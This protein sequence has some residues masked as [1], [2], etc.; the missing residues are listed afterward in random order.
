M[1]NV[2]SIRKIENCGGLTLKNGKP[3]VYR[4]GWQVA[5]H[6]VECNTPEETMKA[7][8]SFGG[9]CGIWREDKDSKP[10]Y[11]VD[12]SFRVDTKRQALEIGRNHNQISVLRWKG[13]KLV[14]C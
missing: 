3:I 6:G 8:K 5:T 11:Y 7:I 10:V 12:Y 13:M 1:I 2:R 4:S 9:D 14:Y